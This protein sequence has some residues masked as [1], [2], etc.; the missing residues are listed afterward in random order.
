MRLSPVSSHFLSYSFSYPFVRRFFSMTVLALS[1][2]A[3]TVEK[4]PVFSDR[5]DQAVFSN[6]YSQQVYHALTAEL[7]R[8]Y[9]DLSQATDHYSQIMEDNDSLAVAKRLTRL[10]LEHSDYQLALKSVERWVAQAPDSLDA[11]QFRALLNIRHDHPQ[12]AAEDLLWLQKAVDKKDSGRGT[13][14]VTSIVSLEAE[15]EKAFKAFKAFTELTEEATS[16]KLALTALAINAK[17]FD[18]AKAAIE[19]LLN[20]KK[21]EDQERAHLLYSK[22]LVGLGQ[23]QQAL[24]SLSPYYKTSKNREL[25]LEYARLL[26]VNDK[27]TEAL[28][29]YQE[30]S[31][32]YPNNSDV[33]YTLGLLHLE[34]KQ[35]KEALPILQHL[36]ELPGRRAEGYYFLGEAYEGLTQFDKALAAYQEAMSKGFQSE[37]QIRIVGLIKDTQGIDAALD[38]LRT[39]RDQ[40]S[41]NDDRFQVYMLEGGLFYDE[42]RYQEALQAYAASKIV[43]PEENI[44]RLYAESLVYTAMKEIPKAETNL[45][46]ILQTEPKNASALNALGYTLTLHTKRWDEAKKLIEQ[47]LEVRPDDPAITDSLAWVEY[48][49][50]NLQKAEALLRK[51]YNDLPD[52]EVAAHLIEVLFKAGKEAEAQAMLD[53]ELS[54]HPNDDHL[55]AMQDKLIGGLQ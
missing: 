5:A 15:K 25:K 29:I 41:N 48:R 13:L 33:F 49:L 10:A 12:K 31:K 32:A 4:T 27:T 1:L 17:K 43:K 39:Q 36:T 30:L 8:H 45:R 21:T 28:N 7:Y 52:P 50:G 26:I 54:K 35:F 2:Q 53:K 24:E 44:D 9:G 18:E 11:R 23:K 16:A 19:P 22:A 55:K 40:L 46:Q 51:A 37:A 38:Y 6:D 3:C 34:K 42:K 47:A 20:S 14:F